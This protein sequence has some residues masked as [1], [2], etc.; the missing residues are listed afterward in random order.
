MEYVS[1]L[2]PPKKE[3][4]QSIS[5]QGLENAYHEVSKTIYGPTPRPSPVPKH[6]LYGQQNTLNAFEDPRPSV[7]P[8]IPPHQVVEGGPK[9]WPSPEPP[10][11]TPEEISVNNLKISKEQVPKVEEKPQL[12]STVLTR[13]RVRN[14]LPGGS[15]NTEPKDNS[16]E[17]KPRPVQQ[18]PVQV[19]TTE[20]PVTTEKVSTTTTQRP[21]RLSAYERYKNLREKYLAKF[22]KNSGEDK[23]SGENEEVSSPQGEVPEEVVRTRQPR[24]KQEPKV[25]EKQEEELKEDA[26]DSTETQKPTAGRGRFQPSRG[27]LRNNWKPSTNGP[28]ISTDLTPVYSR[29][30][31]T[32][33][34]PVYS[35]EK[36]TG[37]RKPMSARERLQGLY[38][39]RPGMAQTEKPEEVAEVLADDKGEEVKEQEV[40]IESIDVGGPLDNGALEP[41]GGNEENVEESPEGKV[42]S[43]ESNKESQGEENHVEDAQGGSDTTEN[44][45][46]EEREDTNNDY[47]SGDGR[48][49]EVTSVDKENEDPADDEEEGKEQGGSE[50]KESNGQQPDPT[51]ASLPFPSF[52]TQEPVLPLQSLFSVDFN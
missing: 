12:P 21:S 5:E 36:A 11:P 2:P 4:P 44:P 48:K 39:R 23:G 9:D 50:Q 14:R 15:R 31:A 43:E 34:T 26:E 13:Q 10:R 41:P 8:A 1:F 30:K 51:Q 6:K 16:I 18:Q 25:V 7:K 42:E 3:V 46:S 37:G 17:V 40:K 52:A 29:E 24:P 33:P 28:T 32:E 27:S 35:R 20:P 19:A 49:E 47:Q 45:E 38:R 22:K